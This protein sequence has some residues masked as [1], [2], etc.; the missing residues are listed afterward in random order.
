MNMEIVSE[1]P[2][3]NSTLT[4]PVA[5]EDIA[6]FVLFLNV[7]YESMLQVLLIFHIILAEVP[8]LC[9]GYLWFSE[10]GMAL[11]KV[12]SYKNKDW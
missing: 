4:W 9:P 11:N 6:I 8:L 5:H 3:T 10:Q 1:M 12:Y 2:H 7:S